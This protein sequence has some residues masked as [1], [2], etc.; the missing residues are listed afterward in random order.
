VNVWDDGYPS[1]GNY[2]SN[3]NGTDLYSGPYQ[4]ETGSDGIGDTPYTIDANDTDNFPIVNS[5]TN[6]T[7]SYVN[8]TRKG[9][10]F[11]VELTTNVTVTDLKETPGSIKLSVSGMT[12]DSGYVR[13]T[14]PI[15]LNSSDI[16][17]F[18][19]NTRLSFPSYDPPAS[20]SDNDTHYF[21]YLMIVFQ[22]TYNVTIWFPMAG[23]V[24]ADGVVDIFDCVI[25]AIAFGSKISDPAPPWNPYA[26][27]NNDGTVDIFDI[28]VVALHFGETG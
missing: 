12:G 16:K 11:P 24:N 2:W 22:S 5:W 17:V 1:G 19:N 23:D 18:L 20:I 25:V 10:T 28:V 27:I 4:N 14:Q 9:I 8:V 6:T 21:I 26:D 7:T 13:I 3:Y 15:G